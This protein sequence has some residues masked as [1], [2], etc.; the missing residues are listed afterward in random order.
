MGVPIATEIGIV[1][2]R[3][4]GG[5]HED[6][7]QIIGAAI[8]TVTR[9]HRCDDNDEG[10]RGRQIEAARPDF[11]SGNIDAH[12][13]PDPEK[14]AQRRENTGM[15]ATAGVRKA[16]QSS[17]GGGGGKGSAWRVISSVVS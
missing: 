14:S 13:G 16:G 4:I 9:V 3:K 1:R 11:S 12:R 17:Q 10:I 7:F 8:A 2:A 5:G 15:A 6:G